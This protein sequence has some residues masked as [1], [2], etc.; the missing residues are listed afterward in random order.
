MAAVGGEVAVAALSHEV[1][2]SQL[3]KLSQSTEAW[4]TQSHVS[5]VYVNI[6]R[7]ELLQKS[8]FCKSS[9]CERFREQ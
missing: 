5:S 6:F 1:F 4:S 3:Y 8:H 9:L 2:N 7:A